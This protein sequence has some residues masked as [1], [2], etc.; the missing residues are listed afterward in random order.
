MD[1]K[2]HHGLHPLTG[3][4][5]AHRNSVRSIGDP[6]NF[7]AWVGAIRSESEK[8]KRTCCLYPRP[9]DQQTFAL[10]KPC[11]SIKKK[12]E[13][14]LRAKPEKQSLCPVLNQSLPNL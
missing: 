12:G 1:P 9:V 6:R 13:W 8:K 5:L 14:V 2:G 3:G 11:D 10:D 7:S 4:H